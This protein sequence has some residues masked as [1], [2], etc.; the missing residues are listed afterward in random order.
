MEVTVTNRP[1]PSD[2]SFHTLVE[3]SVDGLLVIDAEGAVLFANP[4]AVTFFSCNIHD[5]KGFQ[6]GIPAIN[7]PVVITIPA[8]QGL[9]YFEMR[10][11]EIQWQG[12]PAYLASLRDV[13]QRVKAEAAL[14]ESNQRLNAILEHSPLMIN[15]IDPEGRYIH[16]NSATASFFGKPSTELVGKTF[17]QLLPQEI[18]ELFW[19]RI[20]LVKKTRSPLT[21][22]DRISNDLLDR[23]Y[24]T[25]LFPLFD[26]SGV[27]R[28]IGGIAHD[29][30]DQKRAEHEIVEQKKFL[31]TVLQTTP[32]GFWIVSLKCAITHV[33]DA[34]CKMSGYS[35]NEL[36]SLTISDIEANE[37]PDETAIRINRIV[38]NGSEIFE[39]RH[40]RKD[41]QLFDVEVSV[42]FLDVNGGILVCFCRDITS[43]KQAEKALLESERRIRELAENM[44]VMI[45]ALTQDS[46]F[47]FWNKTC[48]DITGYSKEEII[49]NPHAM[50]LLYPDEAYRQDL[51]TEWDNSKSV[52]TNKEIALTAKDG[53]IHHIVWTNLSHELTFTGSDI[54]AIGIDITERKQAELEKETLQEQLYHVQKIESIG[55]LAG[56]VAHYYNNMLCAIQ[57]YSEMALS[58]LSPNDSLRHSI[59]SIITAARYSANITNQLLAYARKQTIQPRE[60]DLNHSVSE[61]LELLDHLTSESVTLKW[62]PCEQLWTIY[63]DPA[64]INQ[65]LVNLVVNARDAI[66]NDGIIT[67]ETNNIV[68]DQAYCVHQPNFSP[69]E[70]VLLTVSDNG[71]GMDQQT[72]ER[73]FEPFFT[74]KNIG[75]GTGL[76]LASVYGIVLQNKGYIHA[77]SELGIGT[78]FKIYLPRY[79]KK[80]DP[81][82]DNRVDE[83]PPEGC[84]T[85][86]LVEDEPMVLDIIKAMLNRLGYTVLVA[87]SPS[88]AIT[89]AETYKDEIHLFMTDVIMPEMDG[90]KLAQKIVDI[91]PGVKCLFTSGY[92]ADVISDLGV[93]NPGVHFISKPLSMKDLAVKVRNALEA[94]VNV[95]PK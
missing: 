24:I 95:I 43:R 36:L 20:D 54:W 1:Q 49:G 23:H 86:L 79:I 81:I 40:R 68:V 58:K 64:Q 91:L 42:K 6:I 50:E 74:T 31:T 18:S 15:E 61:S 3:L 32:D 29:I 38:A 75:E 10:T 70:Y 56:G 44:P 4:A 11:N 5:L 2:V 72:L 26:D 13:T 27:V 73:I 25:T 39:T 16:V 41:G 53:G 80:I 51:K 88:E 30:S 35:E 14:R 37:T 34:Y 77:Y 59:E 89:I 66:S 85:I 57:G 9:Q 63:S 52:Y 55:Q 19:R 78:T 28:S 7:E 67:I 76:G 83:S 47:T 84:K 22:V 33:N 82:G 87:D 8:N 17:H 94:N 60:L 65:I 90:R 21:V 48:E 45:N 92:T 71:C 46:I 93:L 69:G 62:H 12:E